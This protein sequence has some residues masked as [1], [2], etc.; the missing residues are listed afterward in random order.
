MAK[1]TLVV[2]TNPVSADAEAEYNDWYN[3]THLADVVAVEGFVSAQRFR[4]VDVPAMSDAPT[5]DHRYLA[6]YEVEADDIGAVAEAL[7]ASAGTDAMVI[8][9]ALD[10]A[11]ARMFFVEPIGAAVSAVPA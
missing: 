5:P 2:L 6:L 9:P 3:N 7:V 10:A 8:S 11:S 1:A 4:V